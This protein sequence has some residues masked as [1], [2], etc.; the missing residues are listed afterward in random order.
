MDAANGVKIFQMAQLTQLFDERRQQFLLPTVTHGTR[1]KNKIL[2][3]FQG[4]LVEQGVGRE[5]KT[6]IFFDGL[7]TLVKKALLTREYNKEMQAIVK[8][9]KIIREDIFNHTNFKFT[10]T[11]DQKCQQDSL[12]PSLMALVSMIIHLSKSI[13][14]FMSC[15]GITH[16]FGE[17][18]PIQIYFSSQNIPVHKMLC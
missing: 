9:V 11:F 15:Q 17:V 12:P 6:L 1:L 7:N 14:P 10:G 3:A 18:Y 2:D 5:P 13:F 8:A 16:A 4:D